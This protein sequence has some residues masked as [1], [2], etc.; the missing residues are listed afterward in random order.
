MNMAVDDSPDVSKIV[1][2]L[3]LS[4]FPRDRDA[5]HLHALGVEMILSMTLRRPGR[6]YRRHPFRLLHLP[7]IDS[8][9]TPIPIWL[10]QH[11]VKAAVTEIRDGKGVLVHCHAGVHRSVGM[12]CCILVGKGYS[13]DDAMRL[14]KER[15]KVAD[16]DAW[17]IKRRIRAFERR[18]QERPG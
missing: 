11:G 17:Y 13:A 1:D 5:D 9:L 15:R 18:W 3:Y 16:P 6:V 2:G 10:L 7:A 8:P 14:V 12:T 4:S